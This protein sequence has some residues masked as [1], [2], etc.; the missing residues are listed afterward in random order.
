LVI[1]T[2]MRPKPLDVLEMLLLEL[3][4]RTGLTFSLT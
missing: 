4:M 1:Q 2:L 3:T